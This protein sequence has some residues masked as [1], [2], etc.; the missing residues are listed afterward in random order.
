VS[1]RVP[2]PTTAQ[3]QAAIEELQTAAG[4]TGTPVSVLAVATHLSLANTTFWRHFP[5]AAEQIRAGARPQP[6]HSEEAAT[7]GRL[8]EAQLRRA[9]T[10]LSANLALAAAN[11]QRLSLDNHQ[12]REELTALTGVI[13]IDRPRL[14][15]P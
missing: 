3:V 2:L 14:H 12:L 10:D 4:S 8:R 7:T 13:P 5:E 1:R 6:R 11:I 9:N 15:Q